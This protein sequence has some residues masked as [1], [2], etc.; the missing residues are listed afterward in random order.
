VPL[1]AKS[2]DEA[3]ERYSCLVIHRYTQHENLNRL[4]LHSRVVLPRN[5]RYMVTF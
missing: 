3:V 4:T 2:S 5:T 1:S